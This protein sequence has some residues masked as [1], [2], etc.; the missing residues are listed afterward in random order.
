V[1]DVRKTNI[2]LLALVGDVAKAILVDFQ[3][4]EGL[5]GN[6]VRP[7]H[8][9]LKL[10]PP[11]RLQRNQRLQRL[12]VLSCLHLRLGFLLLDEL[13]ALF[14]LSRSDRKPVVG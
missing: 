6:E 1:F 7:D 11:S 5:F 13:Q 2:N 12:A 9:V 4:S 14:N 10:L 3:I 8:Q